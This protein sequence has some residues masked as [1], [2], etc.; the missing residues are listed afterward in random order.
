MGVF[1][2]KAAVIPASSALFMILFMLVPPGFA[3]VILL[4]RGW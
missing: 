3:V 2:I 4:D 1:I